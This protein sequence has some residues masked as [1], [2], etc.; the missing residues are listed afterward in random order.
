[1]VD[2]IKLLIEKPKMFL[3]SSN[4]RKSA[5]VNK[6]SEEHYSCFT[7]FAYFII[8]C[9]FRHFHSTKLQAAVFPQNNVFFKNTLSLAHFVQDALK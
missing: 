5:T 3:L 6:T 4:P 9:N 1:M 2:K 7:L 8:N